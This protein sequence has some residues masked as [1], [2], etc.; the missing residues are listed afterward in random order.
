[1]VLNEK[2]KVPSTFEILKTVLNRT[3][4]K[5]KS[6]LQKWSFLDGIGRSCIFENTDL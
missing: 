1:M 6:P 3:E 5:L 2:L 4:W